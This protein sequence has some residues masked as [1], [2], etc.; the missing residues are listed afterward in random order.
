MTN[1]KKTIYL[2]LATV[3]LFAVYNL[4]VF[5]IPNER[6]ASFWISYVFTAIAFVILFAFPLTLINDSE[7]KKDKF[8]GWPLLT[9]CVRFFVLQLIVGLILMYAKLPVF[10]T[11]ILQAIILAGFCIL[12]VS[13]E[14]TKE[15]VSGVEQK[16]K[17]NS[18]FIRLLTFKAENLYTSE[19]DLAK[20]AILKKLYEKAK[21]SDPMSTTSAIQ[22]YDS[23]ID[24]LFSTL[25]SKES[26]MTEEDLKAET[27]KL[28]ALIDE[29]NRLC[30]ISK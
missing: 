29:R 21:Y 20:K 8:L 10:L 9:I 16:V 19:A 25:L 5:L 30:M 12:A 11:V 22:D 27:E 17:E 4:Y 2:A 15:I 13:A 3:I 24:L 1:R 26:T 14:A 23:R 7:V 6:T 28:I 18:Q